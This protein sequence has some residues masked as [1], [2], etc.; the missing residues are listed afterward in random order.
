LRRRGLGK[1]RARAFL[2]PQ[3]SGNLAKKFFRAQALLDK[4]L[5]NKIDPVDLMRIQIFTP[6]RIHFGEA[7]A[8]GLWS[9]WL[10]YIYF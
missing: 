8:S 6:F 2:G 5:S 4:K 1:C 9:I 10:R 7:V 3:Q